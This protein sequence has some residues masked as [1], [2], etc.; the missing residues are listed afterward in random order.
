V[1]TRRCLPQRRRYSEIDAEGVDGR[2]SEVVVLPTEVVVRFDAAAQTAEEGKAIAPAQIQSH[3]R[4]GAR[5][6]D[7]EVMKVPTERAVP[8]A[9]YRICQTRRKVSG[10]NRGALGLDAVEI[11][12]RLDRN[13]PTDRQNCEERWGRGHG[14]ECAERTTDAREREAG[15][16][17]AADA[18]RARIPA[19]QAECRL[20]G[21]I[22]RAPGLGPPETQWLRDSPCFWRTP[23]L[24][25]RFYIDRYCETVHKRL[26]RRI[27]ALP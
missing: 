8:P 12:T 10:E 3:D 6:R 5:T 25:S 11:E 16:V 23:V 7:L 18:M 2:K 13:L 15:Q 26:A 17:A 4:F 21:A 22:R 1:R 19:L 20:P 27:S 24:R 14:A 9:T